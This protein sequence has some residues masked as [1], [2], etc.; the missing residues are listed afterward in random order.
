MTQRA[1]CLDVGTQGPLTAGG[2]ADDHHLCR[3]RRKH[4]SLIVND[5][6][7]RCNCFLQIKIAT[8]GRGDGTL[9]IMFDYDIAE[10]HV[11]LCIQPLHFSGELIGQGVVVICNAALIWGR[12]VCACGFTFLFTGP[13]LYKVLSLS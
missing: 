4:L 5:K 10:G 7:R 9:E 11:G 6:R 12:K 8:V 2:K 1:A 3:E 13:P